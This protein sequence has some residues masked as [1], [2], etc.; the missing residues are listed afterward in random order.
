MSYLQYL[1]G[2]VTLG[3]EGTPDTTFVMLDADFEQ[4]A[5]GKLN[6]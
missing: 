5:A 4:L 2:K 3:K 6:P 1:I